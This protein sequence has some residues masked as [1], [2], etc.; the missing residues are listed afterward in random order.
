M[1]HTDDL[2]RAAR[3]QLTIIIDVEGVVMADS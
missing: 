1:K 2:T 3:S